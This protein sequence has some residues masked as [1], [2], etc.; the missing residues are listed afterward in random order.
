MLR[1]GIPG[2]TLMQTEAFRGLI[3]ITKN[4]N[5]ADV[6]QHAATT[7][8]SFGSTGADVLLALKR[9]LAVSLVA[10]RSRHSGDAEVSH[11]IADLTTEKLLLDMATLKELDS[12]GLLSALVCSVAQHPNHVRLVHSVQQLLSKIIQVSDSSPPEG[13]LTVKC[14]NAIIITMKANCINEKAFIV[15]GRALCHLSSLCAAQQLGQRT[16]NGGSSNVT[17]RTEDL[18]QAIER[19]SRMHP[20]SE[21]LELVIAK[22]RDAFALWTT[23]LGEHSKEDGIVLVEKKNVIPVED[24]QEKNDQQNDRSPFRKRF[25]RFVTHTATGRYQLV[26]VGLWARRTDGTEQGRAVKTVDAVGSTK[27]DSGLAFQICAKEGVETACRHI[28]CHIPDAPH[29]EDPQPDLCLQGFTLRPAGLS[30]ESCLLTYNS[31]CA[32]LTGFDFGQPA[33]DDPRE[34]LKAKGSLGAMIN[35]FVE[36]E[37][38]LFRED[39]VNGAGRLQLV[40]SQSKQRGNVYA[41]VRLL[42]HHDC[43]A[44]IAAETILPKTELERI[45]DCQ[46]EDLAG[47]CTPRAKERAVNAL[48]SYLLAADQKRSRPTDLITVDTHIRI[49]SEEESS[50]PS[51]TSTLLSSLPSADMKDLLK[52]EGS[53]DTSNK[54]TLANEACTTAP[55][56]IPESSLTNIGPQCT[57]AFG[58]SRAD[59]SLALERRVADDSATPEAADAAIAK[60]AKGNSYL[61]TTFGETLT[62]PVHED[63]GM[64][65]IRVPG[66]ANEGD[67]GNHSA[68]MISSFSSAVQSYIAPA[69]AASIAK[70][71]KR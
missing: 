1:A 63:A 40:L 13:L 30:Q 27:C 58:Q 10:L 70:I 34:E 26:Q 6:A 43:R 41:D 46:L 18:D 19:C 44:R 12:D 7:L 20:E 60:P 51:T 9:G 68:V 38:L 56:V 50:H 61:V 37:T 17:V 25:L 8:L 59:D 23:K 15:F 24:R 66:T 47:S 35:K 36:N 14:M 32:A 45:V 54:V 4:A 21:D 62:D 22:L 11:W 48:L 33:T 16:N 69:M 55:D 57:A 2:P 53:V 28:V 42:K 39:I 65:S 49:S 64:G 3:S 5:A 29:S 52:L 31:E 67:K 71:E